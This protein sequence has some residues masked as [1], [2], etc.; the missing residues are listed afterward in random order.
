DIPP[1]EAEVKGLE[2]E[3]ADWT[4]QWERLTEAQK[5]TATNDYEVR[6][7]WFALESAKAK[8]A[9]SRARLAL[10]NAGAWSPDLDIAKSQLAEAEAAVRA[11]ELLLERRTVRAPIAG[12][13]LKRTV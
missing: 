8:L 7:R 11:T 4:E 10:M 9:Q 13:I 5:Q 12:T 6:R 1:L 2:A 3:V